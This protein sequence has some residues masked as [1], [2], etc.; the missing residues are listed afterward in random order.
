MSIGRKYIYVNFRLEDAIYQSVLLGY[1]TAPTI[2]GLAFQRF[3]MACTCLGVFHKFVEQ[4]DC[5]LEAGWFTPLQL[6]KVGFSLRRKGYLVHHHKALSQAFISSGWV[7]VFPFPWAILSS[8]SSNFLKYSSLLI[9]VESAFCCCSFAS[10]RRYFA[11]RASMSSLS[12]RI[13]K[14]RKISAF[15]CDVVIINRFSWFSRQK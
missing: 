10:L 1:L 4:L 15:I 8:A 2:F 9:N 13:L 3:G 6:C 11:A 14:L 12:A 5:F 7:N